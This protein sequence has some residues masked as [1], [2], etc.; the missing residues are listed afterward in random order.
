MM[1]ERFKIING[2]SGTTLFDDLNKIMIDVDHP[3]WIMLSQLLNNFNNER[4][5]FLDTIERIK[6]LMEMREYEEALSLIYDLQWNLQWG[7][8]ND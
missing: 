5:Y 8:K 1:E 2:P 7:I 3:T 6:N 4:N